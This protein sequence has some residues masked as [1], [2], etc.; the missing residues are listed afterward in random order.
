MIGHKTSKQTE[1]TTFYIFL[2]FYW[3]DIEVFKLCS[4]C[5]ISTF[6]FVSSHASNK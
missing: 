2:A 3:D 5:I 1:I 4:S 6:R